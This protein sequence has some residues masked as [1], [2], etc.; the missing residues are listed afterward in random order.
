MTDTPTPSET[1]RCRNC[2]RSVSAEE[3]DAAGWCA[4]CRAELIRRASRW[5][6][7]MALAISIP[8]VF[9]LAISVDPEAEWPVVIWLLLIA[10]MYFFLFR[11]ARRIAFELVRRRG[12]TPAPE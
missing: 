7:V 10:A 5:A 6:R 3:A 2:E 8:G 1:V 4:D 11:F 12:V 9:L